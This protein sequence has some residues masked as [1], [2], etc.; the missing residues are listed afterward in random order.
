[1]LARFAMEFP[2]YLLLISIKSDLETI[3]FQIEA[4][5]NLR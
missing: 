3:K 1:M 5:I 2:V 4:G